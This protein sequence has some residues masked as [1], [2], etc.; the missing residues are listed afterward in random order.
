[1]QANFI[2]HRNLYELKAC[3]IQDIISYE[4]DIRYYENLLTDNSYL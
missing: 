3:E 4:L 1:M 2:Y